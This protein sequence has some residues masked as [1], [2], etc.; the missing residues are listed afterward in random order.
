MDSV[1]VRVGQ[2]LA[3]ALSRR[4]VRH[5]E[6]ARRLGYSRSAITSF[7][8]G[9]RPIPL[10]VAGCFAAWLDDPEL[11]VTLTQVV[12]GGAAPSWYD[13]PRCD[14]HRMARKSASIIEMAEA[15]AALEESRALIDA[16]S[17]DHLTEAGR[18]ELARIVDELPDAIGELVNLLGR[19]CLQYGLS[20]RD[21]W[22]DRRAEVE[23]KGYV[24][25]GERHAVGV[26]V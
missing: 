18:A 16:A 23:A 2:A 17:A 8:N 9:T 21:A 6:A 15:I 1:T 4:G 14:P 20:Y 26:A 13:G 10:D 5:H 19:L 11:Y 7:C 22:A 25:K 3:A 24:V 12:C